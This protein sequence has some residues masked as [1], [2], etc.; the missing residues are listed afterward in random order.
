MTNIVSLRTSFWKKNTQRK[1]GRKL[2]KK[3][4]GIIDYDP[5]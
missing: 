3:D 4:T 2:S 1:N 5:K